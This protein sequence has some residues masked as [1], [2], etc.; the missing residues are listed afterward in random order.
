MFEIEEFNTLNV[1]HQSFLCTAPTVRIT[2]RMKKL[3]NALY[4][5]FSWCCLPFLFVPFMLSD[6]FSFQGCGQ[7]DFCQF[8]VFKVRLKKIIF[9]N[10]SLQAHFVCSFMVLIL[11]SDTLYLFFFIMSI[12]Y[13]QE[14]IVNPHLVHDFNSVC[15]T[16]MKEPESESLPQ[17][18]CS[19]MCK[20]SNLLGRKATN[21]LNEKW[22]NELWPFWILMGPCR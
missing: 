17:K 4:I 5:L 16:K 19:F 13:V 18:P 2:H 10:F 21:P 22:K 11:C 12:P 9:Y 6:T 1:H 20:L 7:K 14:K 15:T 3:H 8:E